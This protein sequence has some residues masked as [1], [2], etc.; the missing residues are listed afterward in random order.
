MGWLMGLYYVAVLGFLFFVFP[1]G[2]DA[3]QEVLAA[4]QYYGT[5]RAVVATNSTMTLQARNMAQRTD[6]E[7]W[8]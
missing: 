2:F 4:R 1:F 7:L 3:V 5:E 8:E 6:V